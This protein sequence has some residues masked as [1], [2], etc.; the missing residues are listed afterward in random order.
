MAL[1][2]Y[3]VYG[4]W[5]WNTEGWLHR[6]GYHDFAGS[7]VV[8]MVGGF[9]ALAGIAKTVPRMGRFDSSGNPR[10]LHASNLPLVALGTFIL[11]FGWIGF[12]G[13]SAPFGP[14][15]GS[16]VLNTL[17]AGI[18]GGVA[19]LLVGWALRGISGAATIMNGIL[20]GLVAIT[21]SADV[22][23][24]PAACIIGCAGGIAYLVAEEMLLRFGLDDAVS[25]VPVHAVAGFTGIILTG[26]FASQEYLAAL[27]DK[28][29]HAVDRGEAIGIQAMGAAPAP[30]GLS[31]PAISCGPSSAASPGFA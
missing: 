5:I 19:C 3:P 22:V 15:T 10:E 18:F 25:A 13:G 27:G 26:A 29:G 11:I 7:S 24:A 14:Q 23:S 8:H 20:A 28:V 12:N 4:H 21:A 9:V 31:W 1:I 2:I 16:I 30:Y 17:L 6:M